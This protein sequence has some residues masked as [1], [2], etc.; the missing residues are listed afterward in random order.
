MASF[1]V[2]LWLL[3]VFFSDQLYFYE[4]KD[5]TEDWLGTVLACLG[6]I[7]LIIV[8]LVD[9]G[10]CYSEWYRMHFQLIRAIP[11]L[12]FLSI[13]FIVLV[14]SD[15]E[16]ADGASLGVAIL[17]LF[18]LGSTLAWQVALQNYSPKQGCL[19]LVSFNLF[20]WLGVIIFS[21]CIMHWR[22]RIVS[23]YLEEIISHSKHENGVIYFSFKNKKE[24][25]KFFKF[26]SRGK[27]V[28]VSD[29][30]VQVKKNL[31]VYIGTIGFGKEI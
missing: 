12:I 11:L 5:L 27:P 25:L 23:N 3:V 2:G 9:I 18:F 1:F 20:W 8:S 21:S 17:S 14:K 28:S 4:Q 26:S 24:A 7:V 13:L 6:T 19:Y 29:R 31:G 16:S 15:K 22:A 30:E 10:Y